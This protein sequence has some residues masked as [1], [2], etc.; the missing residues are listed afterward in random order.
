MFASIVLLWNLL[1][2]SVQFKDM[3]DS[4][5]SLLLMQSDEL[6]EKEKI[7]R[8]LEVLFETNVDKDRFSGALIE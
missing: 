5:L 3:Q 6:A 2:S 1:P 8:A 4:G 7:D